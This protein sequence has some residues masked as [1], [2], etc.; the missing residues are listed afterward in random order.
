[1]GNKIALS[2]VAASVVAL[3]TVGCGGGS[4]SGSLLKDIEAT[5]APIFY[6][7]ITDIKGNVGEYEENSNIYTFPNGVTYPVILTGGVI[8]KNLDGMANVGADPLNFQQMCT[9][10]GTMINPN[11][12]FACLGATTL[13]QYKA[14]LAKMAADLGTTTA[15]LLKDPSTV[16]PELQ[17]AIAKIYL[18]LDD[19]T[20][21]NN[22]NVAEFIET[23]LDSLIL[24][25]LDN[26]NASIA[27]EEVLFA[28][29]A[30]VTQDFIDAK[31]AELNANN[32]NESNSNESTDTDTDLSS[33]LIAGKT[34][35][36]TDPEETF[37]MHFDA[38][39][40]WEEADESGAW[41]VVS[42]NTFDIIDE[43]GTVTRITFTNGLAVG[44]TV[45]V[46]GH[47]NATIVA[48]Q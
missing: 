39:G 14:N 32:S 48:V 46:V 7:T 34:I 28:G 18:N 29:K 16:S 41:E 47:P 3:F 44:S 42:A 13:D 45:T 8:D 19:V 21:A 4:S 6:A 35:T 43:D 33:A 36:F 1:M 20:N 22:S 10:E 17:R 27:I 12:S 30:T 38:S 40:G 24:D 15:E 9:W 11:T 2:F 5:R 26:Q 37:T 25:N 23:T 31:L